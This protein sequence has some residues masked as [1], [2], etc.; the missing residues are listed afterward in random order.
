MK[1]YLIIGDPVDHS[2]SP[3]IHNYWFKKNNIEETYEKK[4]TN[5]KGN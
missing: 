1:K 2:L 5:L 3:K 4:K